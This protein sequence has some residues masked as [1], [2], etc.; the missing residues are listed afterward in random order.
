M[1]MPKRGALNNFCDPRDNAAFYQEP[2]PQLF[3]ELAH[4]HGV[5]TDGAENWIARPLLAV[6]CF[7]C[8]N[9]MEAGAK[10]AVQFF[11]PWWLFLLLFCAAD[12]RVRQSLWGGYVIYTLIVIIFLKNFQIIAFS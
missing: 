5:S 3:L 10:R 11:H 12:K 1:A 8:R 4:A 9:E 7:A 2:I 6:A